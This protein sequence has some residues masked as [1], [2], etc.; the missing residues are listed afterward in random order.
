MNIKKQE[1]L[2]EKDFIAATKDYWPKNISKKQLKEN[3][4]AYRK[5]VGK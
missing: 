1:I 5:R 4:L 3:F 2:N